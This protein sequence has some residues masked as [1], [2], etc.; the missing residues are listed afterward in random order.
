MTCLIHD[1]WLCEKPWM[2]TI[3]GPV[4]LPQTCAEIVRPSGVFTETALNFLSCAMAL[5]WRRGGRGS[6]AATD[7]PAR[8]RTSDACVM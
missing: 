7:M 6:S 4:G 5:A 3:S 1:K 8:R 2:K